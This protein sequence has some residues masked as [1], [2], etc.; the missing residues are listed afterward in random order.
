MGELTV[1]AELGDGL[2]LPL[3]TEEVERVVHWVLRAEGVSD[4]ELSI[5]LVSDEDIA[6]MNQRYLGHEGPT[7]VI[8][9]PLHRPGGPPVGDV[10][11]GAEQAL[12]QA[13]GSGVAPREEVLRLA[14]HGTLHVLG[15][16]HPEGPD[17]EGS[18]M[19]LRQEALL[20]GFLAGTPP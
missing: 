9:F 5:A 3:A 4:A 7:D 14:V 10:Y 8:S 17:R 19:Y 6:A 18:P 1:D 20:A 12:R 16:E 13:E 15:Y 11:I 2:S